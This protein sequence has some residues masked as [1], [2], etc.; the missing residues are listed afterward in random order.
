MMEVSLKPVPNIYT[1]LDAD[2]QEIRVLQILKPLDE[3]D[4]NQFI[5]CTLKPVSLKD[6]PGYAALSY[7]WARGVEES[8]SLPRCFVNE[9]EIYPTRNLLLALSSIVG[10]ELAIWVD[11]IC[12]NQQDLNE[13]GHQVRMMYRIYSSAARV[14]IWLGQEQDQSNLAFDLIERLYRGSNT[15]KALRKLTEKQLANTQLAAHWGALSRLWERSYWRRSWIVQELVVAEPACSTIMCGPRKVSFFLVLQTV[16][17]IASLSFDPRFSSSARILS[18]L[19]YPFSPS[20]RRYSAISDSMIPE[21]IRPSLEMLCGSAAPLLSIVNFIVPSSVNKRSE[22]L[23]LLDLLLSFSST[24][25]GDKRDKVYS[26]LG[27]AKPFSIPLLEINYSVSWQEVY[28]RTTIYI[29]QGLRTLNILVCAGSPS[30]DLPSWIADWNDKVLDCETDLD[31]DPA[32]SVLKTLS[33]GGLRFKSG[34]NFAGGLECNFDQILIDDNLLTVR[35]I[36]ISTIES[37]VYSH[38]PDTMHG[39]D[40]EFARRLRYLVS[41][42][43]R[44]GVVPAALLPYKFA[45]LFIAVAST[46]WCNE[47]EFWPGPEFVEFCERCFRGESSFSDTTPLQQSFLKRGLLQ[48]RSLFKCL[49]PDRSLRKGE[50]AAELLETFLEHDEARTKLRPSIGKDWEQLPISQLIGIS[51]VRF[52]I[53]DQVAVILGCNIPLVLRHVEGTGYFRVVGAAYVTFLMKGEA[54]G[55]LSEVDITLC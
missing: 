35:G 21:S 11:A 44:D 16:L 13:R 19:K 37:T 39:A 52:E 12:I 22:G 51:R 3:E 47:L 32:V 7:E 36:L 34:E 2:R 41:D 26:L 9:H 45:E 23:S 33:A 10:F 4:A 48:D 46:I 25:A 31:W 38:L 30:S 20:K 17:A 24:L 6:K 15:L 43:Q 40:F 50:S 1:P 49:L 28:R 42:F 8:H 55:N 29:I 18:F 54:V 53:G 27:V 5:R 14:S